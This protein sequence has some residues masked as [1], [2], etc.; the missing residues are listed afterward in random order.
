M[1]GHAAVVFDNE[2]RP[3]ALITAK[4]QTSLPIGAEDKG[5]LA[6]IH[7]GPGK[8][9]L[10]SFNHYFMRADAVHSVVNAFGSS[11]ESAFHAENWSEIG[12]NASDPMALGITDRVNFLFVVL[13]AAEWT[14]IIWRCFFDREERIDI[15]SP[16]PWNCDPPF[17]NRIAA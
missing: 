7:G 9:M 6:R 13:I 2:E 3:E 16:L 11:A 4:I 12:E 17:D 10:G 14:G 8:R 5:Q 1:A 15:D